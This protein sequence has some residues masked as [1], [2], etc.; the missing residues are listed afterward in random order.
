M[1]I[2]IFCFRLDENGR[3]VGTPRQSDVIIAM[4]LNVIGF[5]IIPAIAIFS[6]ILPLR[7]SIKT[8]YPDGINKREPV[9][10]IT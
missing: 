3:C 1:N 5:F 4:S 8:V 6:F 2:V 10:I 9:R 7:K